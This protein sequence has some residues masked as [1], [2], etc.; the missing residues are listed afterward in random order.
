MKD[1]FWVKLGLI[2]VCSISVMFLV[3]PILSLFLS[4]WT[5]AIGIFKDE[6][7]ISA[8]TTSLKSTFVSLMVTFILGLPTAYIMARWDFKIKRIINLVIEMPLVLPPAVA[9]LLL[10]I[11]FGKH[12]LLGK[13]LYTIGIEL[14]FSFV[15]VV[16]R[17]EE[18]RVGK[19]CRSRWSPYH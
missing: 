4:P 14:P 10:L 19:E 3:I 7:V 1:N 9:G 16:I 12:G 17:S 13:Y 18:R 2:I 6:F 11:A 15:A 5:K 8:F